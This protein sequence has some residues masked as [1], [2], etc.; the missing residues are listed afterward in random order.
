MMSLSY[1]KYFIMSYVNIIFIK[2]GMDI[3]IL[4]KIKETIMF[5]NM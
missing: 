1:P 4:V 5:I 2:I 3:Y